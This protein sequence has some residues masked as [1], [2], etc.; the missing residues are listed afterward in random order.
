[1]LFPEENAVRI[2]SKNVQTDICYSSVK[3][4]SN[5]L[6]YSIKINR[7]FNGPTIKNLSSIQMWCVLDGILLISQT[8]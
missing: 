8:I 2:T 5:L 4:K 1:M 7:Y 6:N 3:Y